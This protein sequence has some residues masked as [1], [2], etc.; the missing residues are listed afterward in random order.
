MAPERV[1]PGSPSSGVRDME[2]LIDLP[3]LIAQAEAPEPR[4]SAM[5]DVDPGS[6]PK[7][8]AV[9]RSMKE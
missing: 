8:S 4:W 5:I 6:L 7:N 9:L 1:A 3:S 2:V